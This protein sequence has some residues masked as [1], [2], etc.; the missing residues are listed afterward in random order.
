VKFAI[1]KGKSQY[2]VLRYFADDLAAALNQL[3]VETVI[4]DWAHTDTVIPQFIAM[5]ANKELDAV[6]SFNGIT[7]NF[8]MDDGKNLYDDL[9]IP[10]IS[11]FVDHPLGHAKRLNGFPRNGFASFVDKAHVEWTRAY[12]QKSEFRASFFLP[13]AG[14]LADNPA[15]EKTK[16]LLFSGTYKNYSMADVM[17]SGHSPLVISLVGA[18]NEEMG[19]NPDYSF[20]AALDQVLLSEGLC[21]APEA[22]LAMARLLF[23]EVNDLR[24]TANRLEL[25]AFYEQHEIPVDLLG[26]SAWRDYC[27]EKRFLRYVGEMAYPDALDLMTQYRFFLN[28]NNDFSAGSHERFFNAVLNGVCPL[29]PAN[30]Y[31]NGTAELDGLGVFYRRGSHEGLPQ[32]Q[33]DYEAVFERFSERR[34]AVSQE[35]A[36][37]LFGWKG[38][39]IQLIQTLEAIVCL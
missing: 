17:A 26:S 1:H 30:A 31:Y 2:H 10:Y 35:D 36:E 14:R 24:T 22:Y 25:L 12:T 11:I 21:L 29:S 16:G 33:A 39:A 37:I 18:I 34:Q 9:S 27:A 13:H 5:A 38:R 8:R 20:K 28:D 6:V 19:A 15:P 4:L 23:K 7:S 3:G 32:S